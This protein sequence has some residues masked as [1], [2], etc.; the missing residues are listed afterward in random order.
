MEMGREKRERES[1]VSRPPARSGDLARTAESKLPSPGTSFPYLHGR[2]LN[3]L[4]WSLSLQ[5]SCVSHR[6]LGLSPARKT[7]GVSEQTVLDSKA[8]SAHPP[9]WPMTLSSR[10]QRPRGESRGSHVL[11]ERQDT[12]HISCTQNTHICIYAH[13]THHAHIHTQRAHLTSHATCHSHTPY[14]HAWPQHT[15]TVCHTHATYHI[16]FTHT[17][18]V[19]YTHTPCLHA[20][21]QVTQMLHGT[22]T[23]NTH[24]HTQDTCHIHVTHMSHVYATHTTRHTHTHTYISRHTTF[25]S[26]TCHT[27]HTPSPQ[28]TQMATCHTHVIYMHTHNTHTPHTS[29]THTCTHTGLEFRVRRY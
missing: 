26:H 12:S 23:S 9:P 6:L 14:Q 7:E 5:P 28:H 20:Y 11:G 13:A 27:T 16:H 4:P 21:P 15:L 1:Y 29:H 25:T 19:R 2:E 24:V 3:C 10:L 8:G 22:H 17:H 18:A